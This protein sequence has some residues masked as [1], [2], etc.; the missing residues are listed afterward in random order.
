MTRL[1]EKSRVRSVQLSG[2]QDMATG[3]QY[4]Q[5]LDTYVFQDDVTIIGAQLY[6]ENL[7]N[8]AH[9]N[10]DGSYNYSAELTRQGSRN[11]PGS[12]LRNDGNKTWNAVIVVGGSDNRK[13]ELLMFPAGYGVEVDEGESINLLGF[14][15]YVG[16]GGNM[17]FYANATLYYVE[18]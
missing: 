15:I 18:R 1:A 14:M 8:D 2:A 4:D 3:V 13:G 9:S 6:V 16:A 10:A 12:L 5:A 7:V 11:M 17:G